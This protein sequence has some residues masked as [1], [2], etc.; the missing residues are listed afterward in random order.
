MGEKTMSP[1]KRRTSQVDSDELLSLSKSMASIATSVTTISDT[2]LPAV[3]A[4]AREA[5]DGVVRL[6]VAQEELAR[7]MTN[8][9]DAEPAE[10]VCHQNG[11]ISA[12]EKE[13]AGL[14]NKWKWV[15]GVSVPLVLAVIGAYVTINRSDAQIQTRIGVAERT[16]DRHEKTFESIDKTLQ[17]TRA[18]FNR[19]VKAV[20]TKVREAVKEET[21]DTEDLAV[22]LSERE[23]REFL[24]LV[25]KIKNGDG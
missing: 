1:D 6:T 12:Q 13:I 24:R 19:Q 14:G 7:R 16:L 21:I 3:A 11:R 17:A 2:Q 25:R 23:Q 4:D 18:D 9:E 15:A 20:P 22:H 8:V 10:H 5:R